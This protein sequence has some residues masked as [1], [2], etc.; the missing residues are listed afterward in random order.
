[1]A[2]QVMALSIKVAEQVDLLHEPSNR[3][4]SRRW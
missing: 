3:G 4:D 2:E 1:V